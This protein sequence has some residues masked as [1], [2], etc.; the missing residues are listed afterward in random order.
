[1]AIIYLER[2]GSLVQL[3]QPSLEKPPLRCLL[4]ETQSPLVGH[5]GIR[6]S[7]Q[8]PAEISPR[9]MSQ[10]IVLEIAARQDGIDQGKSCRGAVAHRHCDSA[11]QFHYGRGLGPHQ[12]VV[13]G[14]DLR[15]VRGG[16][17]GCTYYSHRGGG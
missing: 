13:E 1:M 14:N 11:I 4:R 7:S 12:H 6:R 10:V 3:A 17:A 5:T 15:P 9:R 2:I 8:S 16:G